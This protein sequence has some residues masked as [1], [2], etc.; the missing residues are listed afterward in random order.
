[1]TIER[2]Q[3]DLLIVKQFV[4]KCSISFSGGEPFI[5]PGFLDLMA[6]CHRNGILAGVTTNGSALNRKNASKF[7]DARP[8]NLC[9]SCDAP[10][11][12]LHDYLR[13]YPGLFQKLSD[14]IKYVRE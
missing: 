4:G 9:V 7:V 10:N 1:M 6:F 8:F 13:G 14:G 2:W 11:A 5:K 3:A 12:E